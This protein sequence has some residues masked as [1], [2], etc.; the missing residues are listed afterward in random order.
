MIDASEVTTE[1]V[2]SLRTGN[3]DIC[4]NKGATRAIVTFPWFSDPQELVPTLR[5]VHAMG[6]DD[7]IECG[8]LPGYSSDTADTNDFDYIMVGVRGG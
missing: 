6:F 8:N 7:E 4:L 3:F 1:W 5:I 2:L